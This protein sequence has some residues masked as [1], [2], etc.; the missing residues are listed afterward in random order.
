MHDMTVITDLKYYI[1]DIDKYKVLSK[2]EEYALA[3]KYYDDGCVDSA[4]KLCLHNLKYAY[5]VAYEFHTRYNGR[6]KFTLQDLVQEANI[7]L[8]IGISRFNP[9]KKFKL[10]SYA[11]N[12]IRVTL[13]Q[14]I[15]KNQSIVKQITRSRLTQLFAKNGSKDSPLLKQCDASLSSPIGGPNA[16]GEFTWEDRLSDDKAVEN[17]SISHASN[18]ELRAKLNPILSSASD[19]EKEILREKLMT[20]DPVTAQDIATKFGVSRQWVSLTEKRLKARLA[21]ELEFLKEDYYET[22]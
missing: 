18:K 19:L 16:E 8:M 5:K 14:F 2:E 22:A 21:S 10:I 6:N 17:E 3:S 12:W 20:Y 13:Q 9:H 4:K 7:G 1:N 11:T 15:I